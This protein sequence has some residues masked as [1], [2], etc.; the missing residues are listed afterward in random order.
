MA[1]DCDAVDA[2]NGSRSR[3]QDGTAG[4]AKMTHVALSATRTRLDCRKKRM[5]QAVY[6]IGKRLG[7]L[8]QG[9][10][11]QLCPEGTDIKEE[12]CST[13]M[14]GKLKRKS[15][16][17]AD[18]STRATR[19]LELIHSDV[20]SVTPTSKGGSNWFVTFI[21]DYSRYTVVYPMKTKGEVLKKFD[22]YRRMVENLHNATIQILRSD[23]GGEYTGK[24]FRQYLVNG[25]GDAARP[26]GTSVSPVSGDNDVVIVSSN[27]E[28]CDTFM[29]SPALEEVVPRP[30]IEEGGQSLEASP[31]EAVPAASPPPAAEQMLDAS[32]PLVA[33]RRSERLAAKPRPNYCCM[34]KGSGAIPDAA[35]VEEALLMPDAE[36]WQN[37]IEEELG[38]L[39]RNGT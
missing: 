13:C 29:E 37:A 30:V 27:A 34:A 7:H 8:H 22:E 24:E 32:P 3:P 21:D 9:A 31:P 11:R 10:V 2:E 18:A 28:D 36:D 26:G 38:N 23:N 19:S 1:K 15:F 12:R 25:S 6:G 14:Q 39:R 33:P 4:Y 5:R 35:T 17:A 16:P 20:G